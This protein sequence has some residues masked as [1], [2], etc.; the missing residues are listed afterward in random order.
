MSKYYKHTYVFTVLS[1][2]EEQELNPLENLGYHVNYGEDCLHSTDHALKEVDGKE[3][4]KL[5][6]DAGSDPE[7]FNLSPELLEENE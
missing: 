4:A 3:M 1:Q 7:F 6:Y 2:S 5:L